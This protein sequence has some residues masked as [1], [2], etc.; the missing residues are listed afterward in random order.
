MSP[1]PI[2]YSQ[3][4]SARLLACAIYWVAVTPA[5]KDEKSPSLSRTKQKRR[6][7]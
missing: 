5:R 7:Q 6:P 4:Y 2:R 1:R 3:R